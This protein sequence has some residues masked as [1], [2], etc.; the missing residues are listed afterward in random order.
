MKETEGTRLNSG[1]KGKAFVITGRLSRTRREFAA[2]IIKRGGNMSGVVTKGTDYLI[3]GEKFGNTK[4]EAAFRH[5][6][7]TITEEEF[8]QLISD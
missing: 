5:G 1:I 3:V 8:M 6:I 4:I 2:E 7:Y